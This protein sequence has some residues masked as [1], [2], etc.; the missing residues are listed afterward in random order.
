MSANEPSSSNSPVV[1]LDVGT[2][3][4]RALLFDGVGRS[5]EGFGEQIAYE[6]TIGA[7]GGVEVAADLLLDLSVRCLSK[8][9]EQVRA[10]GIHPIAIAACT[11]WHGL[12]GVDRA[13]KPVAPVL[14]VFD[15]RSTEQVKQLE[16]RLDSKQVHGRTGC[17]LHTSYW[18]A[19]LLWLG[20][21]RPDA[22]A[23]TDRWIS[24][25]E[26]LFLKVFGAAAASTSMVSATGLWNQV[27]NDY[28][29]EIL[30]ALPIDKLHLAPFGEMD[31]PQTRLLEPYRSLWPAFD[32]IPWFPA[33]G[34]GACDN[35]GSG[36]L[37][38][39]VFSLMAGTSGSMRAVIDSPKVEIPDGL[40]CY[41]VDRSRYVLGGATSNGGE[42]HAWMER[43]LALPAAP[44]AEKE[45]SELQPGAHG[46]LLLPFFAGERSPYWRADLRAAITGLGLGTRAIDI[47]QAALESVALR[48]REIF[49][50]MCSSLG[51]PRTVIASGG[52][53]LRSPAWTQMMADA[54]GMR[55]VTCLEPEATSRG[56]A[57]LA[58]ERL[59]KLRNLADAGVQTGSE[60]PCIPE[61]HRTYM[62][63]LDRQRRLYQKLFG[64]RSDP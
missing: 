61:H 40:W 7:D 36:C 3:S 48:F 23:A 60:H 8:I 30:A 19:K 33:L 50:V 17:R 14:H 41:R 62:A 4:V 37:T 38:R 29:D 56:A 11:F 34:D 2:S 57:L 42:V 26:Y 20:Q 9:H 43:V 1:T 21:N 63:L 45:L 44:D 24:F 35:I 39:D 54:L 53:L 28:D 10:A 15:T 31:L 55:V 16:K 49:D 32:G 51:K 58:L 64:A 46:L 18:P 25:G 59:G 47:L 12:L 6:I 5:Q 52:A 22:F 13:G 27:K